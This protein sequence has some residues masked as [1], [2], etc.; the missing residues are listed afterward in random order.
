MRTNFTGSRI[1]G[2]PQRNNGVTWSKWD[3]LRNPC[4]EA[5]HRLM[6]IASLNDHGLSQDAATSPASSIL[7]Q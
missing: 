7:Y 2:A 4:G 6:A 5:C 3:K 1:E